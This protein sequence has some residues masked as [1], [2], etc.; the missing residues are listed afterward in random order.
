MRA[1]LPQPAGRKGASNQVVIDDDFVRRSIVALLSIVPG[2]VRTTKL[3]LEWVMGT[4]RSV[5]YISQKA[6]KLGACAQE[7]TQGLSLPI[8][9]LAEADEI[10]QVG[11]RA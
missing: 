3:F 4:P 1:L 2:T 7:Y 8:L 10:F 5:G 11:I 9:A 6:K